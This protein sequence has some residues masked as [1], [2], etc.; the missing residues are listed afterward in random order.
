M[1]KIELSCYR[2]INLLNNKYWRWNP[3]EDKYAFIYMY[4]VISILFIVSEDG[5]IF[6]NSGWIFILSIAVFYTCDLQVC[7]LFQKGKVRVCLQMLN[8]SKVNF[9]FAFFPFFAYFGSNI[10][11]ITEGDSVRAVRKTYFMLLNW[12]LNLNCTSSKN[13]NCRKT[14]N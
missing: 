13:E 11:L 2:I 4:I 8:Y 10:Q 5:F 1:V 6:T 9:N 14:F 3:L 7:C 12:I